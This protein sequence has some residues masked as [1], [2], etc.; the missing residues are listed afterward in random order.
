MSVQI[1]I[2]YSHDEYAYKDELIKYCRDLELAGTVEIYTDEQ[3]APGQEWDKE[4]RLA[5]QRAEVVLFLVSKKFIHSR[6]IKEVEL[7]SAIERYNRG[8]VVLIP[9]LLEQLTNEDRD[10][11]PL[12]KFESLPKV[13]KKEVPV[14]EWN[15]QSG[16]YYNIMDGL[17]RSIEGLQK[18]KPFNADV[19]NKLRGFFRKADY[20]SIFRELQK[21]ETGIRKQDTGLYNAYLGLSAEWSKNQTDIIRGVRN[22]EQDKR[23]ILN[24]LLDFI[25]SLE[26]TVS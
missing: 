13:N 8:E 12:Q 5:L 25:D 19:F 4:I 18:N 2:S 11:L 15:P 20:N 14:T 9:V 22:A 16:A 7:Q 3:I 17:K 21:M 10:L 26:T 24:R 1:F 6:Y 23:D